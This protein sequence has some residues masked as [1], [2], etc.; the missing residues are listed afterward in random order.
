[1]RKTL[2][3]A[4]RE[5]KATVQTKGFIIGI[6]LAPVL[7]SGSLIAMALLK[8]RVD[9]TDKRVALVDRSGI[10]AEV[11]VEA[12]NARNTREVHDEES[13]RKVKPAYLIEI[14]EPNDEDPAVQ[15][16]EL[17]DRVR[18]RHLHAFVEIGEEVLHPGENQ[19]ASRISYHAKNAV[20]DD[21]RGWMGW[22]INNHLRRARLADAGVDE[23]NVRDLFHWV[24]VAGMDLVSVDEETGEIQD[25]QRSSEGEA[26]GIP[27]IMLMLIFLL[28]MMGAV[29]LLHSVMEEKSQRIAEV[30]LGSVRPFQFMMG[31][32]LGGIGVSLTGSA[33]YVIGGII[34][35]KRMGLGEYIPYHILPWFFGYMVL[36]ITMLGAMLAALGSACNDAK[37][38]QSLTMPAMVPMMIPMFI[39]MPVL[40]EPLSDFATWL[41]L[42]PPFTPTLMLLR[43]STP[44]GVPTWQPWV[45]LVGVLAFTVLSVWA[46]GRIFRVG[47]LMQGKSPKLPDILRWAIRG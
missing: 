33:V 5:Y 28:T 8:D 22:P 29:P 26:I 9:T 27:I 23:S 1:M 20:M 4:R 10:I 39:L 2:R 12:A 7:M 6:L 18:G 35:V 34:V 15:R 40:K 43:F 41:S 37:D 25:A 38:A 44:A 17:S 32:V 19:E 11:L 13:G 14:V 24:S 3:L 30:L 36:N 45:G 16:L 47:I 46:G 42:F 31:K 21:V